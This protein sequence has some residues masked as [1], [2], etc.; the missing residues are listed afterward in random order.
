MKRILIIENERNIRESLSDLLE[1]MEHEVL[2]ASNGKEGL[3]LAREAAIDLI[4]CD[5]NMPEMNGYEVLA[6]LKKTDLLTFVPFIFLTARS[7]MEELRTGMDLGA[8]DYITKPFTYEGLERAI[9]TAIDKKHHLIDQFYGLQNQLTKEQSKLENLKKINAHDVRGKLAFMQGLFPMIKNGKLPLQY[10]IKKL[11]ESGEELDKSIQQLS[12][13]ANESKSEKLPKNKPLEEINSIWIIDDDMTQNWVTKTMFHEV[14]EHWEI[15]EFNNPLKALNMIEK[16][17]PD[18]ILLDI[19][20]P[21]MNGFEF[22]ERIA[23]YDPRIQVIM[24]SSSVSLED[25]EKSMSYTHIIDYWV[26]PLKAEKIKQ[27]LND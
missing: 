7:K 19:N 27:L 1:L 23:N 20:M 12:E 26:K 6:A 24:L 18:L 15:Q 11:E 22:L 4:L 21:E 17:P 10:G 5:V 9:K 2:Q 16:D 8:D 14:N 3:T 25:I 13:L